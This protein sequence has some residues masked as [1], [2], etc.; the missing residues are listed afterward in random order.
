MDS[1]ALNELTAGRSLG[2]ICEPGHFMAL[3]VPPLQLPSTHDNNW[4]YFTV[5]ITFACHYIKE[6]LELP[7]SYV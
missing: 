4:P 1:E 6:E 7:K 5:G 3:L 2:K